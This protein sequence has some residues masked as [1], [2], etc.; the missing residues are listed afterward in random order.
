[1]EEMEALLKNLPNQSQPPDL[2]KRVRMNFRQRLEKA[3]R[4]RRVVSL[5]F[6][7]AG[8]IWLV[9][10]LLDVKLNVELGGNGLEWAR[11]GI[12][13]LANPG[14]SVR[15]LPSAYEKFQ[16]VIAGNLPPSLWPGIVL[17][18]VGAVLALGCWMPRLS[19]RI[20]A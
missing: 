10:A 1:M 12:S 6:C 8:I 3:R 20:P 9:P 4:I 2:S 13:L 18:A 15:A 5:A 7:L 17:L 11:S 16:F 14:A 19:R